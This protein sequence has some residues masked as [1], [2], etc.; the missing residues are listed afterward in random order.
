MGGLCLASLEEKGGG[1]CRGIKV[2][3]ILWPNEMLLKPH[4][5]KFVNEI[6][7]KTSFE[8]MLC[9]HMGL[10]MC[11]VTRIICFDIKLRSISLRAVT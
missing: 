7:H 11:S 5:E 3:H 1:G 6:C 2:L 8:S 4:L 9:L 10:V